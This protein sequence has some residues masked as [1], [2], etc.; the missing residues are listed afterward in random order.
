[1]TAG[2]PATTERFDCLIVDDEQTLSESTAGYFNLFD[3]R[4]A[5]VATAQECFDFL[6]THEVSLV[7]LDVNLGDDCGFEV[8]KQLRATTDVPIL[9][10][11]ARS[12]DDDV[13]LAL[14]IGGDDYI[15]KP[16]SLSV[17][18][19]KVKAVL[20]RRAPDGEAPVTTQNL[21]ELRFGDHRV[22]VAGQ[23][24]FRPDGEVQL[25]TMEFRLLAY[26]LRHRGRVVAKRELFAEVWGGRAGDGT[27]N[28][29][30][31]RLRE[32]LGDDEQRWIKTVWG[33]G[34]RFENEA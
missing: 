24:V 1:M 29:H 21:D 31:R 2:P 32:K 12:S 18:L 10:V 9:F 34:Y 7:L 27:L 13:L 8:C 33:T 26:L 11:S 30:I 15:A 14:H 4:T 3:V 6:D 16:C 23:R 17:L 28:V 25:T 22:D 5:W 19:A 20:K